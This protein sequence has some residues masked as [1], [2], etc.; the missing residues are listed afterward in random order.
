MALLPATQT[1]A[2]GAE[3]D[4]SLEV[5]AAG[6]A[7]NAFDAVIGYDPKALTQVPWKAVEGEYFVSGCATR[8]H[9]FRP[10]ADRDTITD[11]LMCAGKSL[12]G[13]GQIYLLRF[14]A[15]QSPGT[16]KVRFLP[17]LQFYNAGLFVN[18]DSSSDAVIAIGNARS[19]SVSRDGGQP[20]HVKS[21]SSSPPRRNAKPSSSG[22]S[23][24]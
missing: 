8:F 18:P 2:P 4:L 17:G 23:S 15:S 10:G 5:T 21:R 3:F 16:T 22:A 20:P 14:K 1:V 11:V 13:P 12:T 7:F 19:D 24:P 9:Q 6:S